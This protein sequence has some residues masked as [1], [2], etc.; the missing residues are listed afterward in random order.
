MRLPRLIIYLALGFVCASLLVFVF[1]GA[2]LLE[3]RAS[4]RHLRQLESNI[5][6]LEAANARLR[7]DLEALRSDP[8]LLR[9]QAR[10][11][12]Y[13]REDEYVVRVEGATAPRNSYAVGRIILREPSLPKPAWVFRGV[14]LGLPAL[15]VLR[16]LL[17]PLLRNLRR[18]RGDAHSF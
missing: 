13:F 8:E 7:D 10:E 15:L 9:L 5:L 6:E 16:R 4:S 11:L 18:R 12:G 14:G 2:G 17:L 1:G 3:Y